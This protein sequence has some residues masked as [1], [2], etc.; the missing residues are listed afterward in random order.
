M[1]RRKIL[2]SAY[3]CEPGFG[4]EPGVGWNIAVR[5]AEHHDVWVITRASN[6]STIEA[7]VGAQ[8]TSGLNFVFYDLPRWS[9]WWK[10]GT[11]GVQLYYY[12]WQIGS[13][14]VAR[15]LHRRID[16][17][18][19]HHVTL[20]KYWAPSLLSLLPIPFIWGPVGGGESAPRSFY[21]TYGLRGII[22]EIARS[23][24]KSLAEHDPLVRLTAQSS[25]IA[26][27]ATPDTEARLRQLGAK[28]I[29][30]VPG[31][32]GVSEEQIEDFAAMQTPRK[33]PV[34]FLSVGRLLHWKGVHLALHAFAVA[35]LPDAEYWVVGDGPERAR[36]KKIARSLGIEDRVVFWGNL[37]REE[38]HERFAACHVV[39][40]PSLHDF[41]PTVCFEAMAAGKPVLC[42]RLGGPAVQIDKESG[43]CVPADTPKH[44]IAGLAQGMR[45][46]GRSPELRD[47]MGHAG[48]K[49]VRSLF[50]WNRKIGV[51]LDVYTEALARDQPLSERR[52]EPEVPV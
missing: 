4:S 49:R 21:R 52:N 17:D 26:L 42:L 3:S 45:L 43:V 41:S 32:T 48:R 46:L 47:R 31:Q 27:V 7:V 36:L 6:R 23:L 5:L 20:G 33:R 16:F 19:A 38:T 35:D 39:V 34:R 44:A 40:H 30:H 28:C 29:L 2:L 50:T 22:Y 37:P 14:R 15:K 10:R 13:F 11:R 18:L 25:R 9:R 12:L 1:S 24:G 8:P 51:L